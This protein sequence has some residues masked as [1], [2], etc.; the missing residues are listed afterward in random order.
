MVLWGWFVGSAISGDRDKIA[1]AGDLST[2][3]FLVLMFLFGGVC[4]ERA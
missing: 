3:F 4:E 1:K 2:S